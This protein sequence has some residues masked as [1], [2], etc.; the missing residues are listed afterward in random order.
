MGIDNIQTL[1]NILNHINIGMTVLDEQN[2]VVVWNQFMAKHSGIEEADLLGKNLFDVFSYL[3]KQWLELKLRSVRL[4]RNY[5]FCFVD[6]KA[7]S[8]SIQS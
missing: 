5:I 3:P 7:L 1:Y 6:T 8:F 2:R 4:I